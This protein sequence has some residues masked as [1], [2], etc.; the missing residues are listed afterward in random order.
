MERLVARYLAG[1]LPC[2]T[3]M[4]T[5]V[6]GAIRLT[7]ARGCALFGPYLALPAG[8]YTA[9]I[10]F[11]AGAD[12]TGRV[13]M[14]VAA[15][16]GRSQLREAIFDLENLP[17][18]S[19]HIELDF[20]IDRPQSGCEVRLMCHEPVSALISSIELEYHRPKPENIFFFH[21]RPVP[22]YKK[23]IKQDWV[24]STYYDIAEQERQPF[25]SNGAPFIRMFDT[26]DLANAVELGC[27]HGRHSAYIREN[28]SFGQITLVDINKQNITFCKRRFCHGQAVFIFGEF[29]SRS[30]GSGH[31]KIQFVV[32]L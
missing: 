26:L 19:N 22:Q 4:G 7:D 18:G 20:A 9:R 16:N 32:L 5:A 24:S 8:S 10:H 2:Q 30:G 3:Q 14:D 27:G 13:T 11:A 28:Y 12:R 21:E 15:R 17:S 25:W 1:E 29:G 31:R 23:Q 6:D